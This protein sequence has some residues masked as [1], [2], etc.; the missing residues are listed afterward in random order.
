MSSNEALAGSM[1]PVLYTA[2][3]GRREVKL[4]AFFALR[5]PAFFALRAPGEE[6]CRS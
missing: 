6:R 2:A 3:G 1:G 4:I 5:A